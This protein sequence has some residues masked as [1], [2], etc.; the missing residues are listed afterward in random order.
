MFGLWYQAL[1]YRA[2]GLG[3]LSGLGHPVSGL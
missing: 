3:Y 2:S 1:G